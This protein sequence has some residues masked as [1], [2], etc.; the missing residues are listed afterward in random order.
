MKLKIILILLVIVSIGTVVWINVNKDHKD[1]HNLKTDFTLTATALFDEFNSDPESAN[2]KYLGKVIEVSGTLFE[3]SLG[4][5]TTPPT[6][7]IENKDGSGY[8]N[9]EMDI[10]HADQ[11]DNLSEGQ[12]V[13]L[14]GLCEGF[15]MDVTLGRC[16]VLETK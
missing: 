13:R 14:K 3:I 11:A 9:C 2:K 1:P 16:I 5:E 6:L 10:R 4:D 12:E 8:I 15:I 7:L